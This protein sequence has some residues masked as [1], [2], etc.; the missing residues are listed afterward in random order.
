M[1][2]ASLPESPD[3]LNGWKDIAAYLGKSVRSAQRWERELQLP[4]HRIVTPDGGQIVYA[5]RSEIDAWRAQLQPAADADDTAGAGDADADVQAA[6]GEGVTG[7]QAPRAWYHHTSVRWASAGLAIGMVLG[8]TLYAVLTR[9]SPGVPVLFEFEGSRLVAFTESGRRLWTHDFG[10]AAAHPPSIRRMGDSIDFDGDG[11]H[12]VIVPVRFSNVIGPTVHTL[13]TDAIVVFSSTGRLLWRVQPELTLTDGEQEFTGPW[14]VRYI[15]PTRA[16]DSGR[17]WVAYSHHTWRPGVVF[18]FTRD[19]DY[20]IRYLQGGGRVNSLAFW[21]HA[22]GPFLVA[23]GTLIEPLGA[24]LAVIDLNGPPARSPDE[25]RVLTCEGCPTAPV[26]N[27]TLFPPTEVARGLYQPH[28]FV[29]SVHPIGAGLR[30][31]TDEGFGEGMVGQ[32]DQTFH[33][34]EFEGSARYWSVHRDLTDKGRIDHAADQCSE[35]TIAWPIRFW[36]PGAGWSEYSVI[37]AKSLYSGPPGR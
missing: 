37:P 9:P 29:T 17:F 21:P 27:F 13:E 12:E 34:T 10:R 5:S 1:V 22:E 30:L 24:S 2:D 3:T 28:G 6:A 18:E 19:G 35:R 31:Q 32:V 7:A 26:H 20:S 16:P 33:L 36:R 25:R 8:A 14:H 4:V 15:V 23:G 11:D